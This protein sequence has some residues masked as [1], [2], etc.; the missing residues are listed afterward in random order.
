L[1][2][3]SFFDAAVPRLPIRGL[4]AAAGPDLVPAPDL[5]ADEPEI[6]ASLAA[7]SPKGAAKE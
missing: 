6:R 4:G 2:P 7:T 1:W 3:R 5:D